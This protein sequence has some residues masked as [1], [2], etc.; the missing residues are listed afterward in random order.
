MKKFLL[1]IATFIF[2]TI[3]CVVTAGAETYGD[4]EYTLLDDGTVEITGYTGSA[5]ELEIPSKIDGKKVTSIGN[6]S[7]LGCKT[8]TSVTIPDSV[9]SIGEHTF[10]SCSSLESV[11][12]PDSV[13]R[14]GTSAFVSCSSLESIVIPDSVTRIVRGTFIGC[15]SLESVTL[16]N[17]ITSINEYAFMNCSSLKSITIPNSVTSI[18]L[19]AF[20]GCSS[21]ES[22]TIPG[23]VKNIGNGA[24]INCTSL[25]SLTILDGVTYIENSA[26]ICTALT[27]VTIPDSVTY[28]GDYVFRN[29]E[30]LESITIPDSVKSIGVYAFDNCSEDLVINCY[31]DSSAHS[32]AL[33][34]NIAVSFIPTDMKGFSLGGRASNAL[35]LNW[36]KNTSAEGYI[37]EQYKNGAWTQIAKIADGTTNFYRATGL[38]PSTE[39]KFRMK[40]YVTDGTKTLYSDYTS[41]ISTYTGPS[42]MSGFKFGGRASNAIRLNWTKNTSADGYIIEQ[43][44]DGQWVRV[45]KITNNATTTYKISGL[46]ASTTYKFRMKAYNMVGSVGYHGGYTGTV[47]ATTS[48]SPV[49]GFKFGGRAN[50]AIR[51]NWTKNTS[52]DGYIIEQYKNGQWVRVAKI[53]NNATTTYK[54]SGLKP[55]TTY[56]FRMKAY[57]MVGS[58]GLYGGYTSTV[59]ATTNPSAI[60]GFKVGGKTS[61]VIRLNW[62]KNTSADGYIIEQYKDG[63][64][65]RIKKVT[66]NATTTYR[67]TGLKS[68]TTYKFRIK[69]YNMVGSTGLYGAYA[70]VNGK[71][72]K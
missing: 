33:E 19:Q 32:Y 36:T 49:S 9:T 60:S 17:N 26:F 8:F 56:K 59:S 12:I 21:L 25:K 24:F 15:S 2:T 57:N 64:W 6:T 66:S 10:A 46:K 69:A 16:S 35:R 61:N 4:Y 71:T 34:N 27:S 14:I 18:G 48:P 42:A 67:V 22:I 53:T 50:N 58:T 30:T 39:Y 72:N 13:T 70:T 29:C 44:K 65:V 43:Y 31:K 52:A 23:N 40:A 55:S 41:T 63:K 1:F 28:I 54:I 45:A 62:T 38:T 37:I 11:I 7:F 20:L 47:S 3:L 68:A 5:T 51:L